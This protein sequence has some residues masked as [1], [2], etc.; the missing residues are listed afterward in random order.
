MGW[1]PIAVYAFDV[2]GTLVDDTVIF[3]TTI[4]MM[5]RRYGLASMPHEEL[6]RRFGQPWTKIFTDGGVVRTDEEFYESYNEI[7]TSFAPAE[8]APGALDTLLRLRELGFRLAIVTA[9]KYWVSERSL[10]RFLQMNLFLETHFGIGDK[11]SVLRGISDSLGPLAYVGDQV[12]DALH[13]KK[14]GATS[15]AYTGG[16][17]SEDMLRA[18]EPDYVIHAFPALVSLPVEAY[19]SPSA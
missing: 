14:A 17:H 6:R 5:R 9:Q 12:G 2:N 10:R 3:L 11:A 8:C 13:A 19:R 15:V 7:Y 4:N 16:I 1:T 18:V